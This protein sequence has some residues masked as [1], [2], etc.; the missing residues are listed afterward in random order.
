MQQENQLLWATYSN[1]PII[2]HKMNIKNVKK[3]PLTKDFLKFVLLVSSTKKK[4]KKKS[5]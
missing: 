2:F 5:N 1:K 4:P 3:K